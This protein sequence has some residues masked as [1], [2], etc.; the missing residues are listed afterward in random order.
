M[1]KTE[2]QALFRPMSPDL[3]SEASQKLRTRLTEEE[4]FNIFYEAVNILQQHDGRAGRELFC[5]NSWPYGPLPIYMEYKE[6]EPM[7]MFRHCD[8]F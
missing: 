3:Q 2:S 5:R 6:P 1:I 4:Y 8:S 7:G